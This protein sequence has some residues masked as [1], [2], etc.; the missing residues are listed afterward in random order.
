MCA[1]GAWGASGSLTPGETLRP[2]S[3][4]R[5]SQSWPWPWPCAAQRAGCDLHAWLAWQATGQEGGQTS[6]RRLCVC[7]RERQASGPLCLRATL[8][9]TLRL[10]P[11]EALG[12]P[13]G[14]EQR[15][16]GHVLPELRR[17][18]G[19]GGPSGQPLGRRWSRLQQLVS[20]RDA[21][22]H[23]QAAAVPPG[24]CDTASWGLGT[25][26]SPSEGMACDWPRSLGHGAETQEVK[27]LGLPSGS[28]LGRGA[29]SPRA[30]LG[31]G[32][33]LGK[34]MPTTVPW[35]TSQKWLHSSSHMAAKGR[36]ALPHRDSPVQ[37][38]R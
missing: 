19:S 7:T 2:P 9:A 16:H 18:R 32:L 37:F 20:L 34:E 1:D 27:S 23:S 5:K 15:S 28:R 35:T 6:A 38:S 33:S 30:T 4:C 17:G 3:C 12:I 11:W 29:A 21:G 8:R 14:S 25:P 36:L 24:G 10:L 13:R 22:L 26:G 31:R